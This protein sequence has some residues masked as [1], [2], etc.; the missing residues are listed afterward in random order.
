VG[1]NFIDIIDRQGK[2]FAFVSK[3]MISWHGIRKVSGVL[4]GKF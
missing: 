3:K 2:A 1:I 4:S